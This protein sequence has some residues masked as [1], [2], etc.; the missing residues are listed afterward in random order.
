MKYPLVPIFLFFFC[1]ISCCT[2]VLFLAET[3]QATRAKNDGDSRGRVLGVSEEASLPTTTP[4]VFKYSLPLNPQINTETPRKKDGYAEPVWPGCSSVVLDL[5]SG[6][7]LGGRDYE[8]RRPI[9]SITK[10]AAALAALDCEPDWE[11]IVEIQAG[12]IVAGGRIYVGRGEKASRRDLLSLGLVASDNTAITALGR[13]LSSTTADFVAIM[14]RKAQALGLA[15]TAFVDPAGL[16]DG[17][18][19]TALEVAKLISAAS[20]EPEIREIMLKNS[21][22]IKTVA[23]RT[24]TARTTNK[25]IGIFPQDGILLQG[26]KTGYT[27]AAGYCFAGRF[28]DQNGNEVASAVL[29]ETGPNGRF[30][31]TE[32]LVNWTYRN[33]EWPAVARSG[34]I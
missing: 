7:V 27:K 1:G 2:L 32:K 11:E 9:G 18:I 8:M 30:T 23:G 4:P 29:G 10:L 3:P 25:L 33:Y 21:L 19:S 20:A 14:N 16:G 31:E 6:K 15:Q 17:N 22:T 13:S 26:G 24:F 28:S 5:A 12:D 34:G